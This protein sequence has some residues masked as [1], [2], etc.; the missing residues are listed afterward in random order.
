MNEKVGQ[1]SFELPQQGEMVFDK[2]YSEQTAQL[3][4]EEVRKIVK[5]AYDRTYQLLSQHKANVEKVWLA[6]YLP[7]SLYVSL[8]GECV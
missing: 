7:L 8:A 6:D 4:D 3:I 5:E 1:L 2:P